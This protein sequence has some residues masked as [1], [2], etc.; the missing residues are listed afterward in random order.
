[1]EPEYVTAPHRGPR[2]R[3]GSEE[4]E[5]SAWTSLTHRQPKTCSLGGPNRVRIT[6]VGVPRHADAGIARQYALELLVGL[7][8]AVRH[9]N[10][11]CVERV[12][13]THPAAL[14]NRYPR[15]PIRCVQQ[16]VQHGPIGDGIAAVAHAFGFAVR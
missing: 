14:M 8:R 16:R 6:G 9:D 7:R 12:A 4:T 1:K 15:R 10:H 5:G 11:S 13:D 3:G 2:A